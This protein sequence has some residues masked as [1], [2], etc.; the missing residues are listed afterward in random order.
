MYALRATRV[1][2][3]YHRLAVVTPMPTA[4]LDIDMPHRRRLNDAKRRAIAEM[5][6]NAS[7]PKRRF[8]RFLQRML[9]AK[10]MGL[11]F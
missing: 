10:A 3:N 11:G 6:R 9:F 5:K 4:T 1:G 7:R 2:G 8:N